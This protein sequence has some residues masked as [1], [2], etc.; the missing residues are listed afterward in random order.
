L[1]SGEEGILSRWAKRKQSVHEEELREKPVTAELKVEADPA[2]ADSEPPTDA[3]QLRDEPPDE[4]TR[5]QWIEELEAID[6]DALTYDNDFTIFMKSW[7]P[8]A[9]R[10]R[11]L[12]KL[13]T[14]NP[15]LA[16]LDGLN[17]YDLDYTD[18]AMQ[19]GTVISSY[20]PG[21]GYASIEEVVDKVAKVVGDEDG[22]GEED[23]PEFGDEAG[24]TASIEIEAV[25]KTTEYGVEVESDAVRVE[26]VE[27]T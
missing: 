8:G 14:T 18:K 10:Q 26:D 16:V 6:L 24:D 25:D 19:A 5:Q 12:R 15:A 13:W 2:I 7:V 9:L 21:K 20:M 4:K 3:A 27:K 17:D 23:M 1:N 11:A 22:A